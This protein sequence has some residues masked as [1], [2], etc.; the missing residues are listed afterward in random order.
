MQL[1]AFTYRHFVLTMLVAVH[2][3]A[4]RAA[5][6]LDMILALA[7]V[8]APA[9]AG[10]SAKLGGRRGLAV[11]IICVGVLVPLTLFAVFVVPAAA[12][13]LRDMLLALKDQMPALRQAIEEWILKLGMVD[14]GFDIDETF[15]KVWEL[16]Q[17][18]GMGGAAAAM[19]GKVSLG[20][21]LGVAQVFVGCVVL[22]ILAASWDVT[23]HWTRKLIADVSPDQAVR[24]FR[25]AEAAQINGIAMVRGLGVMSL[26]FTASYLVILAAIGMPLGKVIVLGLTLG[27]LS[28]LPAVGGFVSATLSLLIGIAHWGPW[29]W[30]TWVLYASGIVAHF[31]E[32]KFLTPRIVGHAIDV[33]PFIMIGVLLSGVALNGGA[34]V[35]Q[36]LILLPIL[37]AMLEE[38]STGHAASKPAAEPRIVTT[39][40]TS[41]LGKKA[42]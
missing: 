40:P 42:S 13:S 29:G 26:I 2:I 9:V 1:S 39:T 41:D 35:F 6:E 38:L 4:P 14:V 30:Q 31:I 23:V 36:A 7:A 10:L 37:R 8:M 3:F 22:A 17:K 28:S 16:L 27:L 25:I 21:L 15:G 34:G 18:E 32:A 5:F 24:I 11:M 20:L 33:P 12:K 19:V